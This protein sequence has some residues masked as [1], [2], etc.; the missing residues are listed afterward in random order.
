MK[1]CAYE[2]AWKPSACLLQAHR[3][4]ARNG[5]GQERGWQGGEERVTTGPVCMR[6]VWFDKEGRMS[7]VPRIRADWIDLHKWSRSSLT[8]SQREQPSQRGR[9]SSQLTPSRYFFTLISVPFCSPVARDPH[10]LPLGFSSSHSPLNAAALQIVQ[11]CLLYYEHWDNQAFTNGLVRDSFLFLFFSSFLSLSLSQGIPFASQT[12]EYSQ[13]ES[14][15][16]NVKFRFVNPRV[17]DWI[18]SRGEK[19]RGQTTLYSAI[20]SESTTAEGKITRAL[21][22]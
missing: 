15:F 3:G 6:C 19:S 21:D 4:K 12:R 5:K 10:A 13:G 1:S 11:R 17:F 22:R 2:V 18:K 8:A 14:K 16:R 9:R 20:S 7:R